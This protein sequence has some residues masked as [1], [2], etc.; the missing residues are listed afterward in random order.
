MPTVDKDNGWMD[1]LYINDESLATTNNYTRMTSVRERQ[2]ECV[3]KKHLLFPH[4]RNLN[5]TQQ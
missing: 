4:T 5:T 1:T 2:L 3:Y